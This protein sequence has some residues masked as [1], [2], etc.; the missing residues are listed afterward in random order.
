MQSTNPICK[1][2]EE[3]LDAFHDGELEATERASVEQHLNQC[4]HCVEKLAEIDRLVHTLKTMPRL[5]ASSEFSSKLDNLIDQQTKV[6]R[7]RSK[8]WMPIAAA[9]AVVAIAFGLRSGM[10]SLS[11][12]N[13]NDAPTIAQQSKMTIHRAASKDDTDSNTQ[14]QPTVLEQKPDQ[15]EQIIASFPHAASHTSGTTRNTVLTHKTATAVPEALGLASPTYNLPAAPKASPTYTKTTIAPA[16]TDDTTLSDS[17]EIAELPAS[18]DSFTDAIGIS[19]DEDGL[20]D[21]K[22]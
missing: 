17:E 12:N 8:A 19:T 18:T 7:F 13:S 6:A 11:P 22:M 4:Q 5:V 21:I 10:P 15:A 9:A 3:S 16:T 1:Q 2:I 20:Y 14:H